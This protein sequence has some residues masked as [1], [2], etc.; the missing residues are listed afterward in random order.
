MNQAGSKTYGYIAVNALICLLTIFY[1]IHNADLHTAST[2]YVQ[3]W[4]ILS[5]VA[6]HSYAWMRQG[7]SDLSLAYLFFL[8]V[9]IFNC[10]KAILFVF[11]P[12][13][14]EPLFSFFNERHSLVLI[15]AYEYSYLCLFAMSAAMLFAGNHQPIR[16]QPIPSKQ[17]EAIKLTG[18]LFLLVSVPAALYDLLDMIRLVLSGGYFA[19]FNTEQ[20]YGASGIVKVLGF[21]LFPALYITLIGYHDNRRIV[22]VLFV[23]AA[24]FTLAKLAMGARLVA[25]VPFL[26][27]LSLCDV[28]IRRVGRKAIYMIAAGLIVVVFPALSLLRVG[29]QLEEG[30]GMAH[31]LF[32]IVKEM[33][34]S[35]SPLV[36]IMQRVPS[37]M[38][39]IN[40]HSFL[41]AASTAVP[42]LFWDVHP[43]QKGSLSSWL[44]NEV[45]PWMAAQGGGF[46]FSI[47]AEF[48]L[49]FY[50]FGIPLLF[51]TTLLITRL[52]KVR[53]N[54]INTAFCFSCF[55][56][57]MLWP[58]GELVAVARFIIWNAGIPWL[59]YRILIGLIPA[60]RLHNR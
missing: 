49:N 6:I 20:A 13:Y 44:V 58:R 12:N 26:I 53:A 30:G 14:H 41:L 60:F 40:G 57:L 25:L 33:S 45:D 5:L 18:A 52:A 46:G 1:R 4:A 32:V 21:F 35:I 47:F 2:L 15:R 16:Q 56:G 50:W 3:S 10:G 17:L 39:F 37:E 43:A 24:V 48:Y 19:L 27:M 7:G 36:W 42:N 23:L 9:F 28:S 11:F 22:R 55:L 51:L 59:C 31:S 34:D 38:D 8:M 54:P 29:D